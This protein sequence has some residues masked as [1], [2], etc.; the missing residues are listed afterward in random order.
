MNR[1]LGLVSE[2]RNTLGAHHE[3]PLSNIS[4]RAI[5]QKNHLIRSIPGGGTSAVDK[6]RIVVTGHSSG[7]CY[8]KT[9]M[10]SQFK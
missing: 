4:G 9:W 5:G 8:D 7:I 2:T 1:E 3:V 10:L 6:L